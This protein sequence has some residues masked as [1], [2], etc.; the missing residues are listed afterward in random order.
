MHN[1][2][3]TENLPTKIFPSARP[4]PFL[5]SNNNVKQNKNDA[6]VCETD[7]GIISNTLVFVLVNIVRLVSTFTHTIHAWTDCTGGVDDMMMT[8]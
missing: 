3:L 1:E 2:N 7:V 6:S 5:K 8:R 4:S